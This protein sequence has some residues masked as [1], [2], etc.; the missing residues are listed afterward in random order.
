MV[1]RQDSLALST[2][3]T[4]YFC[5][6]HFDVRRPQPT[7]SWLINNKPISE[8][9]LLKN[10][11]KVII[12]RIK[13]GAVD[14]SWLNT[15]VKCQATNTALLSPH[16][17][18]A[19]VEMLLRPLSVSIT[20]KPGIMS[21][22][23]EITIVCVSHGS[24]PPAQLTWFRDNRKYTRGKNSEYS[25]ET[26]TV[27]RLGMAPRPED[28][29]AL[30]RCRA[31]NPVLRVAIE[32]SFRMSVVY[33]P[34]LTLSLGSTLNANDIKE[35]DDVYFECNIRANPKEHR[36]SWYHNDQLVSQNMSSG[37][38]FSTKSL[39]LQRVTRKDGGLY[40][41]RAANH[42]GESTSQ[43]VYL[44]VQFAP[45][46]DNMTPS[47]VGA[48][49]DEPLRVRCAVSADPADVTF[50]WQFNNSGESFDVSPARYGGTTSEL[51]YRAASER[52]YGALLCRATNS[53]GSQIRP[54]VF[55]IVPASRPSPPRNCTT[56]R[57][58]K[59]NEAQ[60]AVRCVAG[61][62]GG[63]IQ[64]FTL[65]ALSDTARVLANTTAIGLD[66][67]VWLNVSW[68]ALERL[69]EEEA[70]VVISKN[71]KGPSEPYFLKNLVFRDAAK[72]TE[73]TARTTLKLPAAVAL[74]ALLAVLATVAAL[75]VVALRRYENDYERRRA[76][77]GASSKRPSQSVVQTDARGRRYVVAY[78]APECKP[79]IIKPESEPPRVVLESSDSKTYSLREAGKTSAC[80]D[81]HSPPPAD[82][83]VPIN[84]FSFIV[85]QVTFTHLNVLTNNAIV[86]NG[87][88]DWHHD[89]IS[90]HRTTPSQEA[91][92]ASVTSLRLRVSMG[93]GDHLL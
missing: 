23:S 49:L 73:D 75:V 58:L 48:R 85:T 72:R 55:Q 61:Y 33:K 67:V 59:A 80:S 31:D 91:G 3:S 7:L 12:S 14:R 47:V 46:C 57:V 27:S 63:L 79:D 68:A 8:H 54:C 28:D 38:I 87:I 37:V 26:A 82:S 40:T 88:G 29:A 25:N 39:V 77:S 86:R 51:R 22:E 6:D 35:G 41:C 50:Y 84:R 44:R 1:R 11:G 62:D 21:A 17:R 76:D 36:I 89:E 53:V 32:D 13:I 90:S 52:D 10:D 5:E 20:N 45:V 34:V 71:S 64:H 78:P 4:I 16:E 18:T 19:R 81:G 56:S 70:L 65:E 74:S 2:N 43:P 69:T 60:L 24:R 83:L 30:M 42:I 15:T 93:G 92:N 66:L 9:T